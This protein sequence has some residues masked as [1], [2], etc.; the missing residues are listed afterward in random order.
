MKHG[1]E[2][3]EQVENSKLRLIIN[4]IC[5]SLQS[6]VSKNIFNEEEEEKL[7]VSLNLQK[8]DLTIFIQTVTSIYSQ[9]AFHLI[10]PAVLE[11]SMKQNFS[12]GNDKVA[13]L[14]HAWIT[15]SEEITNAFKRRS[16][17]PIQVRI[18]TNIGQKYK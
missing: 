5:Q 7:L 1:L 17:F 14:T 12:I 10:K 8:V 13:I 16:I 11:N 4:R 9:A 6:G 2:I 18:N 3:L 15:H